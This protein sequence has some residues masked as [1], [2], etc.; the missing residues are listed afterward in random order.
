MANTVYVLGAGINMVVRHATR[1]IQPPLALNF[2]R[3]L[4]AGLGNAQ[5]ESLF[6]SNRSLYDYVEH[7][8]KLGDHDLSEADFDL[9]E[10]FTLIEYH[11]RDAKRE[12]NVRDYDRLWE[13][14]G[15]LTALF[16]GLLDEIF[17]NQPP[18]EGG[19]SRWL[20]GYWT[21]RRPS[22]P[23]TTIRSWSRP[24]SRRCPADTGT[25]Y[26]PTRHPSTCSSGVKGSPWRSS[27]PSRSQP[28]PTV[29]RFSSCTDR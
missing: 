26:K 29:S 21:R 3:Q 8:W 1:G 24:S 15:Q 12:Q 14:K 5:L 23:S 13:I 16:A 17:A 27:A 10:C 28:R 20:G 9:E 6:E 11:E 25:R 4:H 18:D 22:P 2:F 7:Y 19:S